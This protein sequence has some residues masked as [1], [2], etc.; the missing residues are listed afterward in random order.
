MRR[1]PTLEREFF[2]RPCL[3]VAPDLVGMILVRRDGHGH[4]LAGRIVEVEA[5]L[6][7]GQDP[8][9]HAHRG[10]TPRNQSMFGPPGRLYVYRAY[11]I[12]LCT[13]LVCQP[14]GEG[15]AVLLRAVEPLSGHETMRAY[16][17][18]L[19]DV[20]D[21]WIAAGPGRLSQ[22]FAITHADDG[23]SALRLP[24]SIRRPVGEHGVPKIVAVPR[25]G[26]SKAVGRRY[27]FCEAD[28]RYLS[29]A[30]RT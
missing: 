27:R 9:S 29:R 7:E 24:I 21:K 1:G 19:R 15:A 23:R 2:S 25:I 18:L 6:G 22:A 20:A 17:G 3:E 28:S 5:Y 8:A 10:R 13:N 11:G 26:I 14:E 30:A 16:R 4:T 12:H